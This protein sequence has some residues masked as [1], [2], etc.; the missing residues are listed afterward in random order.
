MLACHSE[1]V[2]NPWVPTMTSLDELEQKLN[3][4]RRD[5]D[6]VTAGFSNFLKLRASLQSSDASLRSSSDNLGRLA[7]FLE[8]NAQGLRES[9]F[10]LQTAAEVL[11]K[12]N[13]K[14]TQEI[15]SISARNLEIMSE[16]I[17]LIYKNCAELP[18][19]V[20][21]APQVSSEN[22]KRRF[23]SKP[24][25]EWIIISLLIALLGVSL[26]DFFV[27]DGSPSELAVS[28]PSELPVS[29]PGNEAPRQIFD[30]DVRN[31]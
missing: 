2:N 3:S 1:A 22:T 24:V 11:S 6:T 7:E 20:Q 13:S 23:G 17:D 25:R 18:L 19:K 5:L 21:A 4:I 9:T 12:H 29:T 10:S 27:N 16:K 8:E 31:P 26:F 15:Q 28:S 14:E 30:I